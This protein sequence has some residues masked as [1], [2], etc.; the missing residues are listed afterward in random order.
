MS[1]LLLMSGGID[2]VSIAAW[3]RP[4]VCVTIDY[5]QRPAEAEIRSA[6]MVCQVLGLNHLVIQ[7]DVSDL[8]AGDLSM[9]SVS[10]HSMHSEF[11]PFRN[12]YL[13]TLGAMV[14]I[15][16]DCH[17]VLIGTVMTDKRHRDGSLQFIDAM[18]ALLELQE[19]S[20]TLSAPALE[21]SSLELVR[22][23]GIPEEVLAWSHSCHISNLACGRCRGCH[24]HSE[25][26]SRFGL[27]R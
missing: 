10:R 3:K 16:N 15:K 25:V 27:H 12:Q 2:S 17:H 4:Q 6:S 11:W 24:K 1:D 8:G 19:A 9:S 14:A 23:S 20:I 21:L 13:I 18:S 5:G 22:R 7:A 26:M